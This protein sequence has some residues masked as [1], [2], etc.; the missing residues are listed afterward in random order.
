[1]CKNPRIAVSSPNNEHKKD[2]PFYDSKILVLWV[3]LWA[4]GPY[5]THVDFLQ[6]GCERWIGDGA[7]HWKKVRS[8]APPAIPVLMDSLKRQCGNNCGLRAGHWWGEELTLKKRGSSA[9]RITCRH[10]LWSCRGERW[11][12]SWYCEGKSWRCQV[13]CGKVVERGIS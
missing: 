12:N 13:G 11:A 2:R 6:F 4:V 9:V 5:N 10:L 3:H 1:M 8:C 7:K